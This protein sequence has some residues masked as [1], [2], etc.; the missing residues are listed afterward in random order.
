VLYSGIGTAKR[1]L[2]LRD[3]CELGREWLKYVEYPKC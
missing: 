3:C 1:C 2:P